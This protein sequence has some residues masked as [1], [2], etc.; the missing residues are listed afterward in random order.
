MVTLFSDVQIVVVIPCQ[1]KIVK[2]EENNQKCIRMLS[3]DSQNALFSW[4][5]EGANMFLENHSL[6]Q[7]PK[8]VDEASNSYVEEQDS[9]SE[10]VKEMCTTGVKHDPNIVLKKIG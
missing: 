6:G 10:W 1:S 2:N 4:M 9:A 3:Q 7:I 5:A 8:V